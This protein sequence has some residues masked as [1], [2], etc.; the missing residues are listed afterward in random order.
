MDNR[1][2]L[3]WVLPLLLSFSIIFPTIQFGDAWLWWVNFLAWSSGITFGIWGFINL[4]LYVVDNIFM[5]WQIAIRTNFQN[6]PAGIAQTIAELRPDQ[7]K[8]LLH[9]TGNAWLVSI[10]KEEDRGPAYL[11]AGA[12]VPIEFVKYV[13]DHS[14]ENGLY[15][16]NRFTDQSYSFDPIFRVHTDRDYYKSFQS[17][18]SANN[19]IEW[20]RGNQPATWNNGWTPARLSKRLD[21]D[22]FTYGERVQPLILSELDASK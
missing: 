8:M 10:S 14:N 19:M 13:L 5:F 18:L 4:I 22:A 3:S 20:P 6:G 21:L 17:W 11:L 16:Q 7:V 15:P 2:S 9:L 1:Y 12:D